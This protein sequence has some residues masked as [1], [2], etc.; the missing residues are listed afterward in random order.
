MYILSS[1]PAVRLLVT[2]AFDPRI[3]ILSFLHATITSV[4]S[5]P[6]N[7]PYT[8]LIPLFVASALIGIN[9]ALFFAY[10]QQA[11]TFP[12]AGSA[13]LAGTIAAFFGIGCAT[14]GPLIATSFVAS[15]GG[16]G[17][18]SQLPLGGGEIGYLGILLLVISVYSLVCALNKPLVC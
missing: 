4:F 16:G 7:L 5:S 14:C 15:I 6:L 9:T 1:L 2:L 10:I 18:L 11:R 8:I 12:V 17:L 3:T 13:G